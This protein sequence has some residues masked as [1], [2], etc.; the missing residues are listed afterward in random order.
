VIKITSNPYT[1]RVLFLLTSTGRTHRRSLKSSIPRC[2]TLEVLEAGGLRLHNQFFILSHSCWVV[3]QFDKRV[4][5]TVH[6]IDPFRKSKDRRLPL[7]PME[8]LRQFV[9]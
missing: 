4:V 6:E 8:I 5:L 9:N 7:I 3:R 1:A 2:E